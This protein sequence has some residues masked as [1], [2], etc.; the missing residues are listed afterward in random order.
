M[1]NKQSNHLQNSLNKKKKIPTQMQE[2]ILLGSKHKHKPEGQNKRNLKH[3]SEY[4]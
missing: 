2:V 1:Q 4:I 3:C